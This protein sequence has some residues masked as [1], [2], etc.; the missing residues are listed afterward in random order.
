M[1]S[2]FW[3]MLPREGKKDVGWVLCQGYSFSP[4]VSWHEAGGLTLEQR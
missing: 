4:Y 1:S 3:S 2:L